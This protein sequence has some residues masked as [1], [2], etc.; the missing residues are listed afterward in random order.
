MER[1]FSGLT[2]REV[3]TWQR[4]TDKM[5]SEDEEV[6]VELGECLAMTSRI[7]VIK[8]PARHQANETESQEAVELKKMERKAEALLTRGM[9]A[10]ASK[11]YALA[12]WCHG[13]RR[14]TYCG[15]RDLVACI[16]P[17]I[18]RE[19]WTH[20]RILL[21]RFPSVFSKPATP[22]HYLATAVGLCVRLPAATDWARQIH[23]DILKLAASASKRL[24]SEKISDI[25]ALA[26]IWAWTDRAK[27]PDTITDNLLELAMIRA[28]RFRPD[29]QLIRC[30]AIA[31]QTLSH[32][33]TKTVEN[34]SKAIV[35]SDL[36]DALC[37]LA[38]QPE[39]MEDSE[40]D[41]R[42]A[43][44][45]SVMFASIQLG[46]DTDK[47]V[48]GVLSKLGGAAPSGPLA[49]TIWYQLQRRNNDRDL[50]NWCSRWIGSDG[51]AWTLSAHERIEE[52]QRFVAL[53]E[54]IGEKK[55]A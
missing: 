18:A 43:L 55:L 34:A 13:L 49:E 17:L 24:P 42:L 10:H 3:I 46:D 5:Y 51:R 14:V 22:R 27:S 28:G 37:I 11:H 47:A 15:N 44:M 9:L 20:I 6:L 1:W 33:S 7:N 41:I 29:P 16:H 21:D 38:S 48:E 23:N 36:C 52:V 8:L 40:R 39:H 30:G 19:A 45:S 35:S 12:E 26:F 54:D 2:A 53:A 4:S 50:R 31:G 32:L 25:A